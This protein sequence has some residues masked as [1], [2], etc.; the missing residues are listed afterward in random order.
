MPIT[1][2]ATLSKDWLAILKKKNNYLKTT[3]PSHF[4]S[5]SRVIRKLR[6]IKKKFLQQKAP[7]G[8]VTKMYP[9]FKKKK[10]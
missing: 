5:I 4:K 10:K 8:R 1:E 7:S 2:L 9:F 6:K 3:Y